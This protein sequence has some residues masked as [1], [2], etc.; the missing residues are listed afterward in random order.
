MQG[1]GHAYLALWLHAVTVEIKNTF[2]YL[3]LEN[4]F[5]INPLF[6]RNDYIH[7]SLHQNERIKRNKGER[8]NPLT[9]GKLVL[10]SSSLTVHN[11]YHKVELCQ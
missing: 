2:K 4:E 3:K 7:Q 9:D 5:V 8:P 6:G 1:F 11:F 10:A